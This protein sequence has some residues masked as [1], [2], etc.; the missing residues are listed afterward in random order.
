M[1]NAILQ[2]TPYEYDDVDLLKYLRIIYKNKK[3][4]MVIVFL[5]M[6][7]TIVTNFLLPKTYNVS[8]SFEIGSIPSEELEKG[9]QINEKIQNDIYGIIIRKNLN[10]KEKNFPKFDIDREE[11]LITITSKTNKVLLTKL[12]LEE[13][14]NIITNDHKKKTDLQQMLLEQ[15]IKTA[16]EKIKITESNTISIQNKIKSID[17]DVIRIQN[18]IKYIDEEKINLEEKIDALQQISLYQQDPGSQFA[19]FSTK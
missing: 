17:D 4:A 5:T 8:T 11:N 19:L 7:I 13:F 10:L 1:S 3:M 9:V 14:N 18:K 6:V 16:K 2:K 12:V 15:T